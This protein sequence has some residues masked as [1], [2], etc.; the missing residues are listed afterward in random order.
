M[1]GAAS[2]TRKSRITRPDDR[3]VAFVMPRSAQLDVDLFHYRKRIID[4]DP[5]LSPYAFDFGVAEQE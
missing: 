2:S 1:P 5:I 4:L 3:G